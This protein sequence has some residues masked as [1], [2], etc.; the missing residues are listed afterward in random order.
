MGEE[1]KWAREERIFAV[2][3]KGENN[4]GWRGIT[5]GTFDDPDWI[6]PT[7][8]IWTRSALHW[9]VFPTDIMKL[10]EQSPD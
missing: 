4:P 9:M 3:G 7:V 8:H 6:K 1:E 10:Q 5:V 2:T